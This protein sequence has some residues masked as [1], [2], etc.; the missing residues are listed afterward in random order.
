MLDRYITQELKLRIAL[1]NEER[2]GGAGAGDAGSGAEG[3]AAEAVALAVFVTPEALA[4]DA[5]TAAAGTEVPEPLVQ[6]VR[7]LAARGRFKGGLGDTEVLPVLGLMPRYQALLLCGLGDAARAEDTD[8][9]RSAGVYAARAAHEHGL[10]RLAAPLP[11]AGR[12]AS[13]E[14]AQALA[15]G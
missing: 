4:A 2:F 1:V 13:R 6:A 3:D 5:W 11:R 10:V 9:W 14:L 15:E 7:S 8:A 12:A